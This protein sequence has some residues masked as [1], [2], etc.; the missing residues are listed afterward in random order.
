MKKH[1]LFLILL[2]SIAFIQ[3]LNANCSDRFNA[4]VA[5]CENSYHSD[6]AWATGTFAL[7]QATSLGAGCLASL[8]ADLLYAEASHGACLDYSSE[9]FYQCIDEY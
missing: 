6:I 1:I 5:N 8:A 9:Q 4:D 3:Q 7:C 2:F